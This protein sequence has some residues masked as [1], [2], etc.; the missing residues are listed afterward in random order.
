M[1]IQ[2]RKIALT[3]VFLTFAVVWRTPRSASGLDY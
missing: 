1:A 2:R 3:L